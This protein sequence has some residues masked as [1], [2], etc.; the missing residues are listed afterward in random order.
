MS[1][2]REFVDKFISSGLVC[3]ISKTTCP[4]CIRVV[5]ALRRAGYSPNVEQIDLRQDAAEVQAYCNEISGT[6]TVPKVFVSGKFI[7]GCDD[8]L[9]KLED[10]SF[11]KL[12]SSS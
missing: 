7:G 8:T 5:E 11:E 4:Y 9:R 1:L 6:R 3:V 12:V 2:A 10:K